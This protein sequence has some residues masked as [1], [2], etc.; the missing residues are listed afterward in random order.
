MT[1]SAL[2]FTRSG[3]FVTGNS[4]E[5]DMEKMRLKRFCSMIDCSRNAV[6]NIENLKKWI[7]VC[8]E[9]GYN[10]VMIYTE[11]TYEIEGHPY[12]GYARGRYTKAELKEI[13][14]YAV[15]RG[16]EIIPFIQTLAHIE[17]IFRWAD[18]KPM[19]DID[20]IL[21]C[22]CDG[23]YE[24]IEDM[25]R[26]LAECFTTR[27][28]NV[29]M[30][31]AHNI[32][33]GR[34]YD[35]H[36]DSVHRELLMR[37]LCRVAEIAK[38]YGF[39]I[40]MWSDMYFNFATG[41]TKYFKPNAEVDGRVSEL[42]PENAELIYWDYYK[43]PQDDYTG[44]M[45][46]HEKLKPGY[47]YAAGVWTWDGFATQNRYSIEALKNNLESCRECG[48]ENVI[49]TCWGDG[50]GECS[51]YEAL[52]ALFF[53]AEYVRGNGD[54][55]SIKARFSERFGLSFDDFMLFDQVV[56]EEKDVFYLS[57]SKYLLYNDPFIG[58]LDT[59]VPE[60]CREDYLEVAR[61]TE[62]L[63]KDERW[64][65]LFET[66]HKLALAVA[67]KCDIGIKIRAAYKSSDR[68]AL[69]EY[70]LELRRIRELVYDFY[71]AFERQWM[72][73][74]KAYG[75]EVQDIRIGGI[76]TRLLHCAD[77]LDA[78]LRGEV[79]EIEELAAE[80]LD[81]HGTRDNPHGERRYL[82]YNKWPEIV[83]AG[84]LAISR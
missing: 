66:N 27:T 51:L 73:E 13:D 17:Q 24:L 3:D 19:H 2:S 70:A 16:I 71:L 34:Y 4:T 1:K 31:E 84:N 49:V 52:P 42:I 14:A 67:A 68:D 65:Y 18:Y 23:V 20:D 35:M 78:Y 63:T 5:I 75:F 74:N 26:T 61:L 72:K 8:A 43:R 36:G 11:D 47:W 55:E 40:C 21:L 54:M 9:M 62:P 44:M 76:M 37:H 29:G 81:V 15:A 56:R 48:V 6:L 79:G 77:R 69:R 57:P 32:G 83:T 41:S 39:D 12:F 10:S 82:R 50:G 33:R 45:R 60:G 28:V 38:K 59:T 30:D 25:F 7:D 58:L 64:G 53:A 22:D 80:L 46:V